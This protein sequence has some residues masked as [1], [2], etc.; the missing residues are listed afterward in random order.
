MFNI[1]L[2]CL[3]IIH[4]IWNQP[5]PIS[6]L[7]SSIVGFL[8]LVV[9][10]AFWFWKRTIH[11]TVRSQK[12]NWNWPQQQPDASTSTSTRGSGVRIIY[13]NW[14]GSL[15]PEP[16]VAWFSW[17]SSWG[18][19]GVWIS[20]VLVDIRPRIGLH[21][22]SSF[23]T[24]EE[25]AKNMDKNSKPYYMMTTWKGVWWHWVWDEQLSYVI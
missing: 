2:N 18:V 9:F 14:T 16:Q 19:C 1:K 7:L 21:W 15:I 13:C 20:V 24:A 6:P 17:V 11:G 23:P 12:G 8:Y 4:L 25:Q 10:S 5:N 3:L 22:I